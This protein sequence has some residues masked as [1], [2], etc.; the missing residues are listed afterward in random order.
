M[1]P[2]YIVISLV[3]I[4]AIALVA[5]IFKQDRKDQKAYEDYLHNQSKPKDEKDI[6]DGL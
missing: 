1:Q 2:N 6:A 4:A 5:Y 3:I